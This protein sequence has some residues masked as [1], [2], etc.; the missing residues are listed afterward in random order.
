MDFTADFIDCRSII[1]KQKRCRS[2]CGSQKTWWIKS[3]THRRVREYSRQS[4]AQ[5]AGSCPEK[6]DSNQVWSKEVR[7][8]WEVIRRQRY[9]KEQNT[10]PVHSKK[11]SNWETST[12]G[13]RCFKKHSRQTCQDCCFKW[14][15][16]SGRDF[17]KC[18]AQTEIYT[19]WEKG[20][21]TQQAQELAQ[22]GD[23]LFFFGSQGMEN[24]YWRYLCPRKRWTR[25]AG[26]LD[27]FS[28]K[29]S[30]IKPCTRTPSPDPKKGRI[31]SAAQAAIDTREDLGVWR[32]TPFIDPLAGEGCLSHL[33]SNAIA[34]PDMS[35]ACVFPF[36]PCWFRWLA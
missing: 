9:L 15:T 7:S 23:V 5:Q 25:K 32:S 13:E 21:V 10:K 14:A 6:H 30:Q 8:N 28:G 19:C 29:M 18:D 24:R 20:G 2:A 26:F 22:S 3:C 34:A 33:S 35:R 16:V 36:P 11:G 1:A 31:G 12:S 4:D 17:Q 27:K